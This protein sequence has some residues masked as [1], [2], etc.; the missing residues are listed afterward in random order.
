MPG[1]RGGALRPARDGERLREDLSRD[2]RGVVSS[3]PLT[4]LTAHPERTAILLDFDGT[5]APIVERPEDARIVGGGRE[6]L[7]ALAARFLLVAVISGRP[8]DIL[9]ELVAVQGVRYEGL[10]GLSDA[11]SLDQA[12]LEEVEAVAASIP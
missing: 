6:V 7:T 10:Y 8:T 9:T 4:E 5:L 2:P 1:G 12:I 11:A 3:D